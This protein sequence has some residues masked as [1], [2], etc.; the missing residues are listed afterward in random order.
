MASAMDASFIEVYAGLWVLFMVLWFVF[1]IRDADRGVG[2]SFAVYVGHGV[3]GVVIGLRHW[4]GSVELPVK[5][6]M[7]PFVVVLEVGGVFCM[8]LLYAE[9]HADHAEFTD[10]V[11]AGLVLKMAGGVAAV[12]LKHFE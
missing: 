1:L 4:M 11:W 5:A 3:S 8:G 10:V 7:L 6:A 2:L 9:L 12:A